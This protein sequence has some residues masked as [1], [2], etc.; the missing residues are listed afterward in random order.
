MSR[1]Y[2]KGTPFFSGSLI[3]NILGIFLGMGSR[4]LRRRAINGGL[5]GLRLTYLLTLA[6]LINV[7]VFLYGS[8][9]YDFFERQLRQQ[10]YFST[11]PKI[12]T[13]SPVVPTPFPVVMST[14]TPSVLLTP[15]SPLVENKNLKSEADTAQSILSTLGN[16]QPENVLMLRSIDQNLKDM[17]LDPQDQ[18]IY[19]TRTLMTSIHQGVGPLVNHY[20]QFTHFLSRQSCPKA[21][22]LAE[23]YLKL[24]NYVDVPTTSKEFNHTIQFNLLKNTV[25]DIFKAAFSVHRAFESPDK[26]T[27][28]IFNQTKIN[29][30]TSEVGFRI[31]AGERGDWNFKEEDI[32]TQC[33][34]LL[35]SIRA[36]KVLHLEWNFQIPLDQVKTLP[37]YLVEL[38]GT[39]LALSLEHSRQ[40][41]Q[42]ALI[43]AIEP[44][45]GPKKEAWLLRDP[46]D[47]QATVHDSLLK[48]ARIV[49]L[50]LDKVAQ[51]A[52]FKTVAW[53][54]AQVP[55]ADR[56][57]FSWVSQDDGHLLSFSL[58]D[59]D[60]PLPALRQYHLKVYAYGRLINKRGQEVTEAEF[61]R[62][63]TKAEDCLISLTDWVRWPLWFVPKF[64]VDVAA[65]DA[66]WTQE[67]QAKMQPAPQGLGTGQGFPEHVMPPVPLITPVPN[68]NKAEV[69]E[70][71]QADPTPTT[72]VT[73]VPP[74]HS[75]EQE[76]FQPYEGP[77]SEV[78]LKGEGDETSAWELPQE[79]REKMK[80]FGDPVPN[81]KG[82]GFRWQTKHGQNDVRIDKGDPTLKYPHQQVDHVR[83]TRN[84]QVIGRDGKPILEVESCPKPSIE[85]DAHIPYHE[86]IKWKGPHHP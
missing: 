70:Y 48:P 59:P 27:P 50:F 21:G 6:L 25:R 16:S 62:G 26:W 38:P 23:N 85:P 54:H 37:N 72:L 33:D 8:H 67:K 86:W 11:L 14:P 55:H 17:G 32:A 58:G 57:G 15:S 40:R 4:F 13:P 1:Q 10:I 45:K 77:S 29:F 36:Q 7:P 47:L 41:Q 49:T 69:E 74:Q 81:K 44:P 19:Q 63:D 64:P 18:K 52:H 76:G 31:L 24:F 56:R 73:P 51:D 46:L 3:T 5:S 9:S 43:S 39:Q 61:A 83:V 71:P 66:R 65:L 20:A 34:K 28:E 35:K 78:L 68:D 42:Q 30:I 60:A 2:Q 82:T 12:P 53:P 80:E 79:A 84:G 22:E 75:L